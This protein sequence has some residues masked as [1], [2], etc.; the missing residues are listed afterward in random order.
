M[1]LVAIGAADMDWQGK[2]S[3]ALPVRSRGLRFPVAA[4]L[5][6]HLC[7]G[8]FALSAISEGAD[9]PIPGD[10]KA[11]EV[12]LVHLQKPEAPRQEAPEPEPVVTKSAPVAT[13]KPAP[14]PVP[15]RRAAPSATP[16]PSHVTEAS[17]SDRPAGVA[18][19]APVAAGAT[20]AISEIIL[21]EARYRVP[22]T[23]AAY[24]RRAR[25]LNQQGEALIRVRLDGEGNAEEVQLWKSSGF[26]L[27]DNAAL[28]AARRWQFEPARRNGMPV[29]AWVQI[30][31]RFSLN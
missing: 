25:D 26:V 24:P 2:G 19:S 27:L 4:S 31:V 12:T 11:I 28:A 23:P 10:P 6:A 3:S 18:A 22:P 1:S 5:A 14:A 29:I 30:P 16:L 21:T 9:A 20:G 13:P 8:A 17:Y 7:L 15:V